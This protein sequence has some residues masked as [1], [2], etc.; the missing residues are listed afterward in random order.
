MLFA[1]GGA[2]YILSRGLIYLMQDKF[3]DCISSKPATTLEDAKLSACIYT[4][5][6]MDAVSLRGLPF[7]NL[8]I[9]GNR[10]NQ[11]LLTT[12]IDNWP[13]YVFSCPYRTCFLIHTRLAKALYN[14]CITILLYL[15]AL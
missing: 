1:H 2:G 4:Q 15:I 7:G 11:Q 13:V 3:Q 9:F 5:A 8:D 12:A 10:H 6:G 14:Y